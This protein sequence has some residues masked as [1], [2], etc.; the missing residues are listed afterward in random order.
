MAKAAKKR[1][2]TCGKCKKEGHNARTCP[3]G[4]GKKEIKSSADIPPPPITGSKTKIDTRYPQT[5]KRMNTV[6]KRE[7]P[8]ADKGAAATASPYRCKKCNAVAILVVVKVKDHDASFKKKKEIFKG[9][10]RCEKCMN[11]PSPSDLILKWG[12]MPDEVVPVPG[13]D[14]A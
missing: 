5:E 6:P 4:K 13:Q 11:K 8:T 14:D 10:T 3:K 1:T 9:E 12:A 7:A 2:V